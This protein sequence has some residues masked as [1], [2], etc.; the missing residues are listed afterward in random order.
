[1]CVCDVIDHSLSSMMQ[2]VKCNVVIAKYMYIEV[3]AHLYAGYQKTC[4]IPKCIH[5]VL[6]QVKFIGPFTEQYL[7][8]E[9]ESL[10]YSHEWNW[11]YIYC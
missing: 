10:V 5:M 8:F 2:L 4:I 6:Y 1:M 9:T 7:I 3:T 11:I